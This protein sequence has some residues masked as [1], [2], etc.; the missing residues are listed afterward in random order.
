MNSFSFEYPFA[1]LIILLFIICAKFCS[2]KVSTIALPHIQIY[3]SLGMF[4][5]KLLIFLKWLVIVLLT[6]SLASPVIKNS[7]KQDDKDG[8]NLALV[9]DSSGSMRE[10]GYDSTNTQTKFEVVQELV[11]DFVKKRANDNLAIVVF[12]E[13]AYT[14]SPLTYDKDMVND[15]IKR[16]SIGIAGEKT[17]LYDGLAMGVKLLKQTK[18][19]NRVII[20]LT[21]GVNTAGFIPKEVSIKLAKEH[22]IKVYTIGIGHEGEYDK[23]VL[24]EIAKQSDGE[25]FGASSRQILKEVYSKINSL[26]QSKIRTNSIVHT[27]YYYQFPLFGAIMALI[28]YVYIRNKRGL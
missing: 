25:F 2:L 13:F 15:I 1:F 26:E 11:S 4:N 27:T 6:I 21:D 20:L 3:Q 5:S 9:I 22:H 7:Y 28:F 19:Q 8:Y 17:A 16:L 10:R 18:G 23:R 14:A 12:G 24:Q